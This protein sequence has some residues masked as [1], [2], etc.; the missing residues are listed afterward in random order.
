MLCARCGAI[1]PDTVPRCDRCGTLLTGASATPLL[2]HPSFAPIA[3]SPFGNEPL[4]QQ[5]DQLPRLQPAGDILTFTS[6]LEHAA[7]AALANR[8]L[9]D[10][11][12][13][14]HVPAIQ[15]NTPALETG[16]THPPNQS[17]EQ[18]DSYAAMY[19]APSPYTPVDTGSQW[20]AW[21]QDDSYAAMYQTPP[22]SQTLG[23]VY[24][25]SGALHN[26][27]PIAQSL[28]NVYPG[29][30]ALHEIDRPQ[31][32][33]GALFGHKFVRPMS[34][35]AFLG[36]TVSGALLLAALVF[37]NPDWAT[38][39]LIAGIVALIAAILLLIATGVRVAL[40][41]LAATN[42]HRLAQVISVALLAL[43]LFLAS[44]IGITQQAGLHA[45]QARY[46]EGQQNWPTAINEYQAAGEAAPVSTNLARVYSE[47][48]ENLSQQQHYADAVTH[49]NTVLQ[50]YAKVAD[51][52]TRVRK[53]LVTTYM[54]WGEADTQK[55]DYANAT[56]HYDALLAFDYCNLACQ[57]LAKPKDA[58]AYAHLAEQQLGTQNFV[59]AV[60]AFTT[61]LANF[62]SSPEAKQAQTHTDYATALWGQ[63]QQQLSTTC[64][65]AVKTYQQLA[66][67]FADT[68]QGQQAATALLQPVIVK[69]HFTASLP[70]GAAYAPTVFLVQG[71]F[72]GIQQAQF[73]PLL[74]N[75]ASVRIQSDGTFTFPSVPQGTYELIWSNDGTLHFYYANSGNT[76]LYTAKLGPLCTY[77]YGAIN[78]A[79]PPFVA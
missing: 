8:E 2:V 47:W 14:L 44:G 50:D 25:G 36:S 63:A 45:A 1:N 22:I 9:A 70:Q 43:L 60:K 62:A 67:Q 11:P 26:T 12:T 69:G 66:Q 51:Q 29:S 35:W 46:L 48:G 56:A 77:D 4:P 55:H 72:V 39:A 65:D 13:H 59:R 58:S 61:L 49:F 38:G 74:R 20:P 27:P 71:L 54:A 23:N 79:I 19:Q 3:H 42:P 75:A 7:D 24:P 73:P 37:F 53:D 10:Y 68:T 6:T 76:V 5:S 40:G 16:S 15:L 78:E 64:T 18:E 31:K 52:L 28:G 21:E 57:N 17:W 33:S 34:L 32:G 30:G 41:L